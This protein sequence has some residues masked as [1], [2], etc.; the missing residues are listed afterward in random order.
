VEN[1]DLVRVRDAV[2]QGW[3]LPAAPGGVPESRAAILE[4][5]AQ[6]VRHL[7]DHDF[8]RLLSAMYLL[9]VSEERF[10]NALAH[11]DRDTA[12]ATLA[13]IILEREIEKMESR[14]RFSRGA[15]GG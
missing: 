1:T 5:L 13:E 11:G 8:N 15:P 10:R 6:R 2:A 3:D 9:D 7:L 4:A 14:E 12:S